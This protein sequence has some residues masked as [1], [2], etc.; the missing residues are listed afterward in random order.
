MK[1]LVRCILATVTVGGCL[2][3]SSQSAQ[4]MSGEGPLVGYAVA[5]Y[6]QTGS[7][8]VAGKSAYCID[9]NGSNPGPVSQWQKE[10]IRGQHKQQGM[11]PAAM[12]AASVT[13][14]TINDRELAEIAWILNAIEPHTNDPDWTTAADHAI[15]LRTAG[16]VTQRDYVEKRRVAVTAAHPRVAEVLSQL[17]KG[18][19]TQAGPYSLELAWIQ[20]PTENTAGSAVV[21]VT[22]TA[23]HLIHAPIVVTV[24]GVT[25]SVIGNLIE[26]K[27]GTGKRVISA[28]A[29]VP[30]S[31]PDL[32]VAKQ[33][34]VPSTA[35]SRAQR[36]V[37]KAT[38]EKIAKKLTT[39]VPSSPKPVVTPTPKPNVTSPV[40]TSS[41]KVSSP[42]ISHSDSPTPSIE[43][44]PSTNKTITSPKQEISQPLIRAGNSTKKNWTGFTFVGAILIGGIWIAVRR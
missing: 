22:S 20:M 29:T 21:K 3:L 26:V 10:D 27:A 15:R 8:K 37:T 43:T 18:A 4:A 34:R 32:M 42:A 1:K 40:I 28:V 17:D 25:Q 12:G 11:N 39:D 31:I 7:L 35:D 13:G 38:A 6:G 33:Y 44:T 19:D 36:N 9:I 16:D 5:G 30:A 23:G 2:G 41:P 24:D 14:S